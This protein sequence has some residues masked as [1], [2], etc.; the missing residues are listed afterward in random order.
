GMIYLILTTISNNAGLLRRR[1][2]KSQSRR[3]LKKFIL[4]YFQNMSNLKAELIF[5]IL[6]NKPKKD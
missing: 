3:K 1:M 6:F 4:L 5:N 2:K